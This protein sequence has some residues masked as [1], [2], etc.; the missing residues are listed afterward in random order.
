M[1]KVRRPGRARAERP[2]ADD[3]LVW[4]TGQAETTSVPDLVTKGLLWAALVALVVCGPAALALGVLRGP[5]VPPPAASSGP[6]DKS[7]QRSV[8]GE[9]AEQLVVTWLESVRGQEAEVE[10]F[11]PT[12]RPRLPKVAWTVR[13]STVLSAQEASPGQWSVKVGV[14]ITRPRVAEQRRYFQVPVQVSED[15]RAVALTLPAPVAGESATQ[16]ADLIYEHRLRSGDAAWAAVEGFLG[17]LAVGAGDVARYTTPGVVI[18]PIVPAPY[19][20]VE[21]TS[22]SSD[23]DLEAVGDAPADGT[24]MRV[25]VYADAV[26]DVG[27]TS[28]DEVS[29]QWPLTL[30]ARDGRWE[31]TAIDPVPVTPEK[32]TSQEPTGPASAPTGGPTAGDP[33]S[34]AE[35]SAGG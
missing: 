21:I 31:I 18:N 23:T 3:G 9:W 35:Q 12:V 8:A 33:E 25:L 34:S 29:V 26:A 32:S 11:A 10:A 22:V 6:A 28:A 27:A 14:T 20:A 7:Q 17:A 19:S 4:D 24:E 5:G 1:V 2:E 13:H 15:L 30:T 16:P